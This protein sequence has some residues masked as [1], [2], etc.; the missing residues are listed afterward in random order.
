M[1][2]LRTQQPDSQ[3]APLRRLP[4]DPDV[5][6]SQ[7]Q[8]AA[9]RQAG[10]INEAVEA[11][12][13]SIGQII[14][15]NVFTFFNLI[16]VVLAALL[17]MVESY[18][19]MLFL[20]IAMA[21]TLIGIV[22]QIRSKMT[23]DKLTVL[24]SPR[25]TVVREGVVQEIAT[26]ELVHSDVVC[27]AAGNQI[28]AD[29]VLLS[30]RVQVNESLVT[31]EADAVDKGPGDTLLSGS[32]VVSGNC[33]AQ[34][35]KVGAESYAAKLTLE[36][37]GNVKHRRSEMVT[38]L[39]RLIR[40]IGIGIIPIGLY[41]FYRQ[42]VVL[43]M[44]LH[45]SVVAT[46][47]ALIGMIPEGLYLLT[48]VALALSVIRLA[49]RKT[50][51]HEMN[52]IETLARVDVLCV[53]KTGTITEPGMQVSGVIGLHP[54]CS[55]DQI[56]TILSAFYGAMDRDNAT[57]E[58]LA[59]R[60]C[61]A[62]PWQARCAIPFS[63]Q[64]KWSG[65][66]FAEQ[67]SFVVGAPDILLPPGHPV[68][69]QAEARQRQGE[70]VLLLAHT[71]APLTRQKPE[72]ALPLALVLLA[73]RIRPE[74]P[75]TFHYFAEQGVQI[76]VISGDNPLT[77]SQ[78]AQRAGI[79][80]AERY[81]D[82]TT[83]TDEAKLARAA[84]AYT[85]FGRVTPDQKRQLIRA[86]KRAGHTVAMTGDGVNDV[87]ALK[88]ADCGIA[89]ASGSDAAFQA[90]QLVLL[91]SDFSAMPQIVMEG[92]RVINNI[93]RAASLFLVKNIF[94]FFMA[95]ITLFAT[96]S[97]P[98]IPLQLSLISALTIGAP[99]MFLALEPNSSR[100]TGRFMRNVLLKAFPGGL[101]DL[102]MLVAVQ[103]CGAVFN[104]SEALRSTLSVAILAFVGLLVLYHVCL[105]LN[106]K[107]ALLLVTMAAGL[108]LAMCCLAPLFSLTPLGWRSTLVLIGLML[109]AYPVLRGLMALSQVVAGWL[110][111][112]QNKWRQRKR[113][114]SA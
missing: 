68:L 111:W 41:L 64:T 31:G 45:E 58:A 35:D 13:Q 23:I 6:L 10:R 62:V 48:S 82:A 91:E 106:W 77:V 84:T 59:E 83:L 113:R 54:A 30:G 19:N 34:L 43:Q 99:S 40:F 108:T 1:K 67:G 15:A 25:A 38:S 105:P 90:A 51:V 110:K 109:A 39:Q 96:F 11:P 89:M 74:A 2:P 66:T 60:F 95:F 73:N 81:V 56:E 61:Q 22:Q 5:G 69:A 107:R 17:V 29:A 78:V 97:Y 53:D 18:K 71:D 50:L 47:A 87:L 72:K 65:V 49:R 28:C 32:F 8:V 103:V 4:V 12:T 104:L 27:F 102:I 80:Q 76:K 52:C 57:A 16:F 9:Q 98:V 14:C 55:P 94:S 75:E 44:D 3:S 101:T 63:S 93:Q 42:H 21:N 36:A 85:V 20:I 46:V 70:R 100:I 114:R 24:S 92:R 26:D 79:A 112:P 7:A 88:D 33:R 86:L 37:K